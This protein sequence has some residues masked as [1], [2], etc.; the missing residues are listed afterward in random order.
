MR[1]ISLSL[2]LICLVCI[3]VL[4]AETIP[5]IRT[6]ADLR[7]LPTTRT[8]DGW[9]VRVGLADP[10]DDAGPYK[11]I[12]C[13]GERKT[14]LETQSVS[15]GAWLGPLG[16]EVVANRAA[17]EL[18]NRDRVKMQLPIHSQDGAQLFCQA[19]P[20]GWL[21]DRV[22]QVSSGQTV[23]FERQL[24]KS[25]HRPRYWTTFIESAK[26]LNRNDA[27]WIVD[28]DPLT[29]CP[30]SAGFENLLAVDQLTGPTT[31]ERPPE[32]ATLPGGTDLAPAWQAFY[33]PRIKS[34]APLT[35][36]LK[37]DL[38]VILDNDL[39]T[40]GPPSEHFLA[41]WWVNDQP[42][43]IDDKGIR[44]MLWMQEVQKKGPISIA[45]GLPK[46]LGQLKNSDRVGVQLLYAN[47]LQDIPTSTEVAHIQR[48][49]QATRIPIPIISNRLNFTIDEHLLSLAGK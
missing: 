37:D 3:P 5:D 6:L 21:D 46:F 30:E 4:A 27:Q 20:F 41:R 24:A 16:V 38:F 49:A 26:R 34:A 11:L 18:R 35:L 33:F 39:G 15:G 2:A 25:E 10:G 48:L 45:F 12:Y 43:A 19:L 31:R 1:N 13:L 36:S 14:K 17:K 7:R 42:I 22:V 29:K 28:P 40:S 32:N 47:E 8:A 23:L 44:R 9:D